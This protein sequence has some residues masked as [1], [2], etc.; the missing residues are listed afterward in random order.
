[1]PAHDLG[2][3]ISLFWIVPFAGLLLAIAILPL[4][5]PKFW[6]YHRNK[7]LIAALFGLPTAIFIALE[8][9]HEIWQVGL[10]YFSF[11]T[12]LA[13]LFIITGGIHLQGDIEAKP[14]TN[15]FFLAIGAV[16]ANLIGTTGASMLLIRAML[17][18]N[19]ERQYSSGRTSIG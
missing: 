13:A 3:T 18:T 16:L 7:A 6:E 14:P 2:T 9:W 12:L 19:R 5:T 4:V 10:D 11:I 1:M 15:V 8:D 17:W